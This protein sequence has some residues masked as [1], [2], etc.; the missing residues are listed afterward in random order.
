MQLYNRNGILYV[1]VNGKRTSSKLKDT[2]SNRK[3]LENQF[4]N[5]EFYN[6]FDVRTKGKRVLEFCEEVLAEKEKKLQAT[7]MNAYYSLYQ[8]R[9]KPFFNKK[10]PHEITPMLLKTWYGS[11]NDKSTLNTCIS[12]ILKPAFE[13]ALIEGYI[14]TTPFIVSTPTIKSDYEIQPFTLDEIDL[15][16]S[17]RESYIRN[18]VGVAL[19]TGARTGEILAL[20]WSNIDFANKSININKTRTS[21]YT[22]KPKTKSSIR[23]I[24]MLPQCE[25][26][27][28]E[29]RKLTGLGKNVFI[30]RNGKTYNHSSDLQVEWFGLLNK[31]KLQKRSIYQTRHTFA[32]I[33]LSNQE[34]PLWVSSMLGHK[35]LS[36][37]LD[38]YTKYVKE[39]RTVK[40]T[41]LD[42]LPLRFAQN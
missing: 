31:L 11:F 20:E 21:G 28:R 33:M 3:L 26:F 18:I 15:I 24:D 19:F 39:D 29:Q 7:T 37:T 30:K 42:S 16:L 9:V 36:I 41:F 1:N 4:K 10:Y 38:I 5:E 2:P 27:L 32:S 40:T 23:V 35:S 6:K 14:K 25:L 13:N 34:N 12:A 17:D 22:K 8:S